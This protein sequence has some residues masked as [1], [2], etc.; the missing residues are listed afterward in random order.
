MSIKRLVLL[1]LVSFLLLYYWVSLSLYQ[2][3]F[4]AVLVTAIN[5]LFL[6][7]E[8]RAS[9]LGKAELTI[10]ILTENFGELPEVL[11]TQLYAARSEVLDEIAV[12]VF[13]MDNL[14]EVW[15]DLNK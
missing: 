7:S 3:I 5:L 13:S 8:Q 6:K 9:Q 4:I 11:E 14:N 2:S 15:N 12:G 1:L 10:R